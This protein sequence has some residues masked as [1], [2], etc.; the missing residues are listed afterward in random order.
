MILPVCFLYSMELLLQFWMSGEK[1][2]D[3]ISRRRPCSR[4]EV[5]IERDCS[6]NVHGAGTPDVGS[7][8]QPIKLHVRASSAAGGVLLNDCADISMSVTQGRGWVDRRTSVGSCSGPVVKGSFLGCSRAA[9][10][11]ENSCVS[12]AVNH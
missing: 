12:I 8:E 3:N 6:G 4:V 5:R 9:A 10:A 1:F 2:P 11:T 7:S